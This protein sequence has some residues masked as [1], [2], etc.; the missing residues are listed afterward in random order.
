MPSQV[1]K[2]SNA[3]TPGIGLFDHQMAWPPLYASHVCH[4]PA[5]I[6]PWSVL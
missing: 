1:T 3:H 5:T 2:K 6:A 4:S